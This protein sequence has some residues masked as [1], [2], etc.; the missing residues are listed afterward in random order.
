[1]TAEPVAD[2]VDEPDADLGAEIAAFDRI[3]KL[4]RLNRNRAGTN[5]AV[6]QVASML[7]DAASPPDPA[8]LLDALTL[9]PRYRRNVDETERNL[10]QAARDADVGWEQIGLALGYQPP[11]RQSAF[12]RAKALGI[13]TTPTPA[14]SRR[15]RGK[16]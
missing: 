6:E 7:V 1:M 10:I 15:R 5:A 14:G 9:M 3:A 4:Y 16:T 2:V 13:S 11:A 12:K 8:I